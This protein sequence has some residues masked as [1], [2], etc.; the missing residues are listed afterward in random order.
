MAF[1]LVSLV[2]SFAQR[3]ED[4][5]SAED[6]AKRQTEHMT[7]FLEL[8]EEQAEKIAAINLKYAKEAQE[9]REEMRKKEEKR[10]EAIK[11]EREKVRTAHNAEL[12]AI[13]TDLQY[14]KLE[15]M[16]EARERKP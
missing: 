15:G 2:S 8:S 13:L 6:M 1:V 4:R 10:R 9:K 3:G 7:E 11:A 12:K 16:Q 14:A 5:P